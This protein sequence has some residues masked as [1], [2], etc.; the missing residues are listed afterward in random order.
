MRTAVVTG[1]ASGIGMGYAT[2][3]VEQGYFVLVTDIDDAKAEQVATRLTA[4][5]P[6]W[7]EAAY[8]DV[9]SADAVAAAVYGVK[10]R[11][12]R[13]DLMFNN[14]GL[15]IG[16]PVEELTVGHWQKAI[17]VMI[18]GVAYGVD[19][20]YKIMVEQGFGGIVNT[21]SMAGF[22]PF[23]YLGPYNTAKFAVVGMTMSLRGE[24]AAHGIH[25]TAVCPIAIHTDIVLGANAGLD[26][27]T[28]EIDYVAALYRRFGHLGHL[29]PN[30]ILQDPV[31]HGRKVLR[32]VQRNRAFVIQPAY[33][34]LLWWLCRAAPTLTPAVGHA[35]TRGANIVRGPVNHAWGRLPGWIR[36]A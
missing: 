12:G 21:A 15:F 24:A 19:A 6:G 31:V 33:G 2:A 35:A 13:L 18:A 10:D 4:L 9:S 26:N 29:L 36:D 11:F 17:D 8:L 32:A 7:A 28:T 1:A 14:A 20:A 27:K 23:S 34:R 16:G 5:G 3:L 22:T 25:V 30:F